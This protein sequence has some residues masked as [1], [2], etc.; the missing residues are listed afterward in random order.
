MSML[1]F[2]VCVTSCYE[3]TTHNAKS[4]YPEWHI[5]GNLKFSD[6]LEVL[7]GVDRHILQASLAATADKV[8]LV[9]VL[10]SAILIDLQNFLWYVCNTR[11]KVMLVILLKLATF[12]DLQSFLLKKL[13]YFLT[14]VLVTA[15]KWSI[16]KF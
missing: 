1:L 16:V 13:W 3:G 8:M 11:R 10:K 4:W 15:L 2:S 6:I 5:L 12:I 7:L 14:V 9:I